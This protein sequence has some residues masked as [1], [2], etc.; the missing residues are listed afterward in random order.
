MLIAPRF[1]AQI[2]ASSFKHSAYT[3]RFPVARLTRGAVKRNRA[4]ISSVVPPVVPVMSMTLETHCD[5][6]FFCALLTREHRAT[7]AVG[8]LGYIRFMR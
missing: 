1:Y 8:S 5:F 7:L 4:N 2:E 6:D 3:T